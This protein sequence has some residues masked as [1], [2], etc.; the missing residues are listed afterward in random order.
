MQVVDVLDAQISEIG[1][2]AFEALTPGEDAC[3]MSK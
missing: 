2:D 3:L 1:Q